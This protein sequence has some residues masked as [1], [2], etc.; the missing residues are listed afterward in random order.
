MRSVSSDL[1]VLSLVN[2]TA[3]SFRVYIMT[4]KEK[5]WAARTSPK[6][7]RDKLLR[8]WCHLDKVPHHIQSHSGVTLKTELGYAQG[9]QLSSR[10]LLLSA[11]NAAALWPYF[12]SPFLHTEGFFCIIPQKPLSTGNPRRLSEEACFKPQLCSPSASGLSPHNPSITGSAKCSWRR[13]Q[14]SSCTAAHWL[15]PLQPDK[16]WQQEEGSECG[17]NRKS[18][19]MRNA[20]NN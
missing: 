19:M 6:S 20:A 18:K 12:M 13:R 4:W 3:S 5:C 14:K 8:L 11:A 10:G 15:K 1:V 16:S 7:L 2:K 17:K 9:I